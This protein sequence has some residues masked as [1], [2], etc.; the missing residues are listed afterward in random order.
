[1]SARKPKLTR[2]LRQKLDAVEAELAR[3]ISGA[4]TGFNM[5]VAIIN[6]NVPGDQAAALAAEIERLKAVERAA[7]ALNHACLTRLD[8]G[9]VAKLAEELEGLRL[10]GKERDAE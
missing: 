2:A 3:E 6:G 8:D 1:M 10:A 9:I 4:R 5:L 7:L